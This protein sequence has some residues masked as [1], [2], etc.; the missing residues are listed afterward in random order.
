[1]SLVE[2][3]GVWGFNGGFRVYSKNMDEKMTCYPP[4]AK[5][6]SPWISV[7]RRNNPPE[8]G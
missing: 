6:G 8:S 1:M 3:D 4:K 2:Y 5:V 7:R